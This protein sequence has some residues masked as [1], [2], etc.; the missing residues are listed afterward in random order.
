MLRL[1]NYDYKLKKL[2]AKSLRV[3]GWTVDKLCSERLEGACFVK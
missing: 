2:I 1:M 3:I